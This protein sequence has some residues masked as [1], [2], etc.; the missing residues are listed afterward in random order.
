MA[1]SPAERRSAVQLGIA[2]TLIVGREFSNGRIPR[3]R[4][5]LGV[6]IVFGALSIVEIFP[7]PWPDVA[8]RFGWLFVLALGI[9]VLSQTTR[10]DGTNLASQIAQLGRPGGGPLFNPQGQA[11]TAAA[12]QTTQGT[13]QRGQVS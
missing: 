1:A 4:Q 7:D 9:T 6:A 13:F 3:P 10:L 8:S 5:V 11:S 12:I 2:Q